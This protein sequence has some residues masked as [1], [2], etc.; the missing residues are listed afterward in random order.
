[1]TKQAVLA[2]VDLWP[3]I[4]IDSKCPHGG[5]ELRRWNRRK[6]VMERTEFLLST[7]EKE[8][9][10][11]TTKSPPM[12]PIPILKA[13]LDTLLDLIKTKKLAA[14]PDL[15]A[16]LRAGLNRG[17]RMGWFSGDIPQPVDFH[18]E[19]TLGLHLKLTHREGAQYS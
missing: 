8:W 18:A 4:K 5:E 6:E 17:A 11:L 3:Q 14:Y 13:K 19:L 15:H 7:L 2:P 12:E 1:M 10:E 16:M 9:P